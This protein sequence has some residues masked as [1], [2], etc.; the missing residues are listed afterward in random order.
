[1][2]M[3]ASAHEYR[4]EGSQESCI[5]DKAKDTDVSLNL[6]NLSSIKH[7]ERESWMSISWHTA[8]TQQNVKL[9]AAQ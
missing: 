7:F 4:M 3:N 5:H 2:F 9:K 8:Q 6:S 1:M